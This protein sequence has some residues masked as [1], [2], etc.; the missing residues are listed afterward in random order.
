LGC[1]PR[2]IAI[3]SLLTGRLNRREDTVALERGL[4]Y[5][6]DLD[7]LRAVAVLLVIAYHAGFPVANDGGNAGVTAFFVLS[8]YLITRLLRQ[9]HDGTGRIDLPAFYRRRAAR[10]A[11]ALLVVAAFIVV[12]GILHGWSGD[13]RLGL[14][15]TVLYAGNWVEAFGGQ[16]GPFGHTWT[17]AI[18]EQFY[19][20]W[21]LLVLL[22]RRWLIWPALFGIVGEPRVGSGPRRF[23]T[24]RRS[25]GA[26]R[27]LL[28]ASGDH[29]AENACLDGFRRRRDPRA[30]L[31]SAAEL[32]RHDADHILAA[33][34]VVT[35]NGCPSAYTPIGKRA[36]HLPVELAADRALRTAGS[37]ADLPVAALSYAG[38]RRSPTDFVKI[39]RILRRQ[40]TR[41]SGLTLVASG[42]DGSLIPLD[43]PDC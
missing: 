3:Y 11:P 16:I 39:G 6:A 5:R 41:L 31:I 22:G 14:V 23:P 40:F 7:G 27:F 15:A 37:A 21:P 12:V 35:A 20:I 25:P 9:E 17:L 19:L 43:C 8:G 29:Q 4:Q 30:R 36:W 13:W 26:T 24:S 33:T 38:R 28:A 1:G 18:E 2:R 34:L 42:L 10:L 32:L